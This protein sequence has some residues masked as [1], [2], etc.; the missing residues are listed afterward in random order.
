[1]S[2]AEQAQDRIIVTG[3]QCEAGLWSCPVMVPTPRPGHPLPA[4]DVGA[5]RV[6]LPHMASTEGV[7]RERGPSS[8][9]AFCGRDPGNAPSGRSECQE[10][11]SFPS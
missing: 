3:V 5:V 8:C 2:W 4:K 6:G 9:A 11:L 10:L 7:S 1:M